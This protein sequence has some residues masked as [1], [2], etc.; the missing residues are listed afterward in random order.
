M[1]NLLLIELAKNFIGRGTPSSTL[2]ELALIDEISELIGELA[3]GSLI[4]D[5]TVIRDALLVAL[6][7]EG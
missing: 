2:E 6:D 3:D 1:N 5:G 4:E 7:V